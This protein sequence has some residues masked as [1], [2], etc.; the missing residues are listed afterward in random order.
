MQVKY[1]PILNK[2][3]KHLYLKYKN[4]YLKL[5]E[6]S[7]G[8]K[9]D[10]ECLI[11]Q[12]FI[13][14][15]YLLLTNDPINYK[16]INDE[17]NQQIIKKIIMNG[18]ESLHLIGTILF[19]LDFDIEKLTELTIKAKICEVYTKR[20][21]NFPLTHDLQLNQIWYKPYYKEDFWDCKLL[22]FMEEYHKFKSTRQSFFLYWKSL[23]NI[24]ILF[25]KITK[26]PSYVLIP[27]K[28][29]IELVNIIGSLPDIICN[30]YINDHFKIKSK[31]CYIYEFKKWNEVKKILI[32]LLIDALD[33]NYDN[34]YRLYRKLICYLHN[35]NN[36]YDN[37]EDF[38]PDYFKYICSSHIEQDTNLTASSEYSEAIQKRLQKAKCNEIKLDRSN[39]E[40]KIK[41]IEENTFLYLS[42]IFPT[43]Y[44]FTRHEFTNF[45]PVS[46]NPVY[47]VDKTKKSLIEIIGHDLESH[48]LI[49]RKMMFNDNPIINEFVHYISSL[50]TPVSNDMELL[51]LLCRK[52]QL[53]ILVNQDLSYNYLLKQVI[54]KIE[55]KRL[56]LYQKYMIYI[57][58]LFHEASIDD[59]AYVPFSLKTFKEKSEKYKLDNINVNNQLITQ[60]IIDEVKADFY[61]YLYENPSFLI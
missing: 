18:G 15:L 47:H 39:L 12:K 40:C 29:F 33:C 43:Q 37:Y 16:D 45:A 32:K 60:E 41:K 14:N 56:T 21:Y 24:S 44:T 4:K 28:S 54:Q 30:P 22:K 38:I 57:Y 8:Y 35:N 23:I 13:Q 36:D 34:I 26:C 58:G 61:K 53:D 10:D 9:N 50:E 31:K 51:E 59:N 55:I 11:I 52:E 3:I 48:K 2:D 42:L 5:K 1:Q 17:F 27:D 7:G 49:D 46:I 20:M 19:L 25:G 6:Q